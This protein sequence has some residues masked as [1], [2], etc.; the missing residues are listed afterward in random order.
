MM[1]LTNVD[2]LLP[3]TNREIARPPTQRR[4][5]HRKHGEQGEER[6]M[7]LSLY[8]TIV[9][10]DDICE[11]FGRERS[12]D[13]QSLNKIS[14]L[15]DVGERREEIQTRRNDE[16]SSTSFELGCTQADAGRWDAALKQ[17][18][19]ALRNQ[20][21]ILGDNHAAIARILIG[22]GTTHAMM[23]S[24]YDAVL[25][26][27]KALLIFQRT[28]ESLDESLDV[29]DAHLM[30]GRVQKFRGN[31]VEAMENF[32]SALAI[33]NSALG[34]LDP[35]ALKVVCVI[36]NLHHQ[37]RRYREALTGYAEVL[38]AYKT[39]G[40]SRNHP[41]FVWVRRHISDRT[42]FADRVANF[43]NDCNVI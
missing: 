18:D 33:R 20:R 7:T 21:E 23:G 11:I 30:V 12:S 40:M 38:S 17:F 39:I 28:S 31:C 13:F 29:A 5:R 10:L 8:T 25:D 37:R 16:L 14:P 6:R 9:D 32:H 27:E 2:A 26:I 15:R 1:I 41:D 35:K 34:H 19:I 22:R 3:T 4:S 42:M 43:W 24:L 36:S